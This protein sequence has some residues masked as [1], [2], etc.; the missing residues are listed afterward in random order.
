[1]LMAQCT[2]DLR[3]K[4]GGGGGWKCNMVTTR[5][6]IYVVPIGRGGGGFAENVTWLQQGYV[7]MYY[8]LE[9]Q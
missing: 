6:C 3:T 2:S 5:L 9:M 1:M 4:G 7:Y 8:P